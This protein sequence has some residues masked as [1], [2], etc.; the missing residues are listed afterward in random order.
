MAV[1]RLCVQE[2]T[3]INKSESITVTCTDPAHT[4]VGQAT[5]SECNCALYN[6]AFTIDAYPTI[7]FSYDVQLKY[8]YEQSGVTFEDFCDVV[9][10]SGSM[11][12]D[13]GVTFCT[14]P[15]AFTLSSSV[16]CDAT[17]ITT[18]TTSVSGPVTFS[19]TLTNLC[20]Q[21]IICVDDTTCP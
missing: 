2:I 8:A 12:F 4:P 9:G 5:P 15:Q 17:A 1:R 6:V 11:T 14:C 21:T 18:T 3:T 7:S 19:F 20:A 10:R 13:E 16:S